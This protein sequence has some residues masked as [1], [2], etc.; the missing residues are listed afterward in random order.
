[1][2]HLLVD[3]FLSWPSCLSCSVVDECNVPLSRVPLSKWEKTADT[4]AFSQGS[5]GQ[6]ALCTQMHRD[7]GDPAHVSLFSLS[8]DGVEVGHDGRARQWRWSEWKVRPL[9]LLSVHRLSTFV[10]SVHSMHRQSNVLE[11]YCSPLSPGDST[12]SQHG[13]E[14][15]ESDSSDASY[16]SPS[17]YNSADFQSSLRGFEMSES[18]RKRLRELEASAF[19]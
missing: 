18:K 4:G 13:D 7:P 17:K 9:W 1:M 19:F 2:W 5:T 14:D 10:K 15:S 11:V 8:Q 12:N 3:Q 16:S 6:D